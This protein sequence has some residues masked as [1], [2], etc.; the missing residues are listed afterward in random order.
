MSPD[1][2][3]L[4]KMR[5]IYNF[6]STELRYVG[7]ELGVGGIQPRRTDLVFASKMGDCKDMSLVLVALLR[8]AGIKAKLALAR[9]RDRGRSD[10]SV[11]FMGEFNHAI[12]YV[13]VPE[14]IFL[15]PTARLTG[16]GE[17]PPTILTSPY[18]LWMRKDTPLSIPEVPYY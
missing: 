6:V 4:D 16:S 13:D 17:L 2:T 12:C 15:D 11:P 9:T 5:K 7:F 10:L 18:W 3:D 8:E 14:H 1:D